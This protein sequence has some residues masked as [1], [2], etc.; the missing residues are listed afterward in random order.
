M[1][2]YIYISNINNMFN[3]NA[4]GCFAASAEESLPGHGKMLTPHCV[5]EH[6]TVTDSMLLLN[7]LLTR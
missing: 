3:V 4:V 5:F 7:A 1:H 2:Y 6:V